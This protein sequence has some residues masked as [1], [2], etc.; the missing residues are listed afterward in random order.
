MWFA[1][2]NG[3]MSS[4]MHIQFSVTIFLQTTFEGI[5]GSHSAGYKDAYLLENNAL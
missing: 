1:S 2:N 4:C 3:E 5:W